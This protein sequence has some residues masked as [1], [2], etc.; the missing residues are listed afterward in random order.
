VVPVA[1]LL[2]GFLTLLFRRGKEPAAT[3]PGPTSPG[4]PPTSFPNEQQLGPTLPGPPSTSFSNEQ[5]LRELDVLRRKGLIS[6]EEY[7]ATRS[8]ILSD[9]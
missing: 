5:R 2:Y 1:L 3:P 9:I 4:A 8:K 7:Q 6:E